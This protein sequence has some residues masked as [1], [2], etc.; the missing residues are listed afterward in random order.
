MCI[1]SAKRNN[2]NPCIKESFFNFPLDFW[3]VFTFVSSPFHLISGSSC[4]ARY[5]ISFN[6]IS[7]KTDTRFRGDSNSM[8]S[9]H[10]ADSQMGDG[11][12]SSK[13]WQ[14]QHLPVCSCWCCCCC[15]FCSCCCSGYSCCCYLLLH[16]PGC[17]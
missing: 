10:L 12:K 9:Q 5:L 4:V 8:Q 13:C 6:Y 16:S 3:G 1:R 11:C 7:L 14:A 15:L 17:C 2:I